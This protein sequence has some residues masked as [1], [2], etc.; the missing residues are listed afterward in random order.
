MKKLIP[1]IIVL[2]CVIRIPIS[3]HGINP[4]WFGV[5]FR[6]SMLTVL[7]LCCLACFCPFI[8]GYNRW[9]AV[10]L[11]LCAVQLFIS[12]S[13]AT[14]ASLGYVTAAIGFYYIICVVKPKTESLLKAI[15]IS[16]YF[17]IGVSLFMYYLFPIILEA[18]GWSLFL[19]TDGKIGLFGNQNMQ[20]A[21]LAACLPAF[22]YKRSW[23]LIPVVII[24]M[25]IAKTYG[26]I[27]ALAVG[28]V[29]YVYF[30]R[31]KI[32]NR[33]PFTTKPW[34]IP[35]AVILILSTSLGLYW[36]FIDNPNLQRHLR[37]TRAYNMS[38]ESPVFGH[39]IGAWKAENVRMHPPGHRFHYKVSDHVHNEYFEVLYDQG[40]IGVLLIFGY[41]VNLLIKANYKNIIPVTGLVIIAANCVPNFPMRIAP[42]IVIAMTYAAMVDMK[43]RE[44]I[45]RL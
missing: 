11:G 26:G 42:I 23:K 8:W 44:I 18:S 10:F 33:L 45:E 21:F 13:D 14:M 28:V 40:W 41:L 35:L 30:M 5:D 19:K 38:L 43:E 39:G 7:V 32:G 31:Y 6:L 12:N 24:C 22:F 1:I 15:R 25:V 36:K 29:F 27:L 37:W 20:S 34:I 2:I 17:T 4:F 3:E 9:I 16:A